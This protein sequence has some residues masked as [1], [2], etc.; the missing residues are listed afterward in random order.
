[1][2]SEEMNTMKVNVLWI[3]QKG[4]IFMIVVV[5]VYF[6]F[7]AY[8]RVRFKTYH[9]NSKLLDFRVIWSETNDALGSIFG[10]SVV[11]LILVYWLFI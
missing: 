10:T 4:L 8:Y 11:V 7:F 6:C 2:T 9:E 5:A 3:V 1:M